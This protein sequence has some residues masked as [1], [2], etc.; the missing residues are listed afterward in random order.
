MISH[1]YKFVF[2]ANQKCASTTIHE[3]LRPYSDKSFTFSIYQK[4]LGTHSDARTVKRYLEKRGYNW[5]DYLV[6]TTIR[7]P[8]DR[9]RSCYRYERDFSQNRDLTDLFTPT[10]K[11]FKKY[12]MGDWF[13]KRFRDIKDFTSD[14]NGNCLVDKIIRVEELDEEMPALL[15]QIGLPIDWEKVPSMNISKK[16]RDLE[17]DEEMLEHL[18]SF[19]F[20][21]FD[22]YE[23]YAEKLS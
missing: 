14:K 5:E 19:H 21:D 8:L 11:D 3:L 12:V 15:D 10:P 7:D 18:R 4:P 22:Y 6:F 23:E 17:F 9:I 16:K 2:L 20:T 1:K 13:L